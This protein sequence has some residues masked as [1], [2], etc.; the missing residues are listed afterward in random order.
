MA[1]PCGRILR[2]FFAERRALQRA[3][4]LAE[5][6]AQ[7]AASEAGDIPAGEATELLPHMPATPEGGT[8]R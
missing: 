6:Q 4:R 5:L 3:Q 7:P 2:D 1:E 8:P